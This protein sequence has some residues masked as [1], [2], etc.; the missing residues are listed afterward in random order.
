MSERQRTRPAALGQ[1]Q[2]C[3]APP[4]SCLAD[5]VLAR[6]RQKPPSS[7][8]FWIAGSNNSAGDCHSQ[9]LVGHRVALQAPM[10]SQLIALAD[11]A[12]WTFLSGS[13]RA[14]RGPSLVQG[15]S[16]PIPTV[17]L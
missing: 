12:G 2:C 8:A 4:G 3:G 16:I 15:S 14:R 1:V 11:E 9:L 5:V 7:S 17:R 6:V 10:Q 13:A